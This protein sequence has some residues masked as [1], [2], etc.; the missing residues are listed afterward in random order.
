M[1]H[2]FTGASKALQLLDMAA[3]A[4]ADVASKKLEA[5]AKAKKEAARDAE[6][7]EL[8]GWLG[9]ERKDR[10]RVRESFVMRCLGFDCKS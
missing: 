8:V 10:G 6:A 5:E 9:M 3:S 1:L 7:T 4:A 2:P